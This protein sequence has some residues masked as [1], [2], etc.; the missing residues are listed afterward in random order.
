MMVE[1]THSFVLPSLS[2]FWWCWWWW[3]LC[4]HPFCGTTCPEMSR[5]SIWGIRGGG[6]SIMLSERS[7]R[8]YC[9]RVG[10]KTSILARAPD[11]VK[12]VLRK[13]S[14][15]PDVIPWD[16]QLILQLRPKYRNQGWQPIKCPVDRKCTPQHKRLRQ[17]EKGTSKH[18]PTSVYTA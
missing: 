7:A 8:S 12:I 16:S 4:F 17:Q 13:T 9:P 2:E 5:G 1:T 15:F 10:R 3:L 6:K 18:S 14:G 11:S